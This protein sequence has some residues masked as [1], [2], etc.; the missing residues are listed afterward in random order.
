MEKARSYHLAANSLEVLNA[1]R[2]THRV[3]SFSKAIYRIMAALALLWLFAAPL[4]A[5]DWSYSVSNGEAII[6]R[7]TGAAN[8]VIVPATLNGLPVVR[9]DS[10]AISRDSIRSVALPA[11][12]RSLHSW[13]I[14]SAGLQSITVDPGNQTYSSSDGALLDKPGTTLLMYPRARAG[15]YTIP[16]G[17]RNITTSAFREARSLEA[18]SIPN[19]VTNISSLAFSQC[20]AL[21]NVTIPGSVQLIGQNAFNNCVRLA[22]VVVEPGVATIGVGAFSACRSLRTVQLGE[23]ITR[24]D[25]SAFSSCDNLEEIMLPNSLSTLLPSAF[26]QCRALKR[27]LVAATHPN[28][29]SVDGVLFNLAQTQLLIYPGG[30]AAEY[31]IPS[32]V[33]AIGDFAFSYAAGLAR[34]VG[35]PGLATIGAQ[36]F[37]SCTNLTSVTLQ[38]SV[39][40]IG[41]GAFG[42]CGEL[43]SFEIPPSVR[44][45]GSGAFS[46]SG[47][48]SISI[49]GSITNVA[50]Q[51][52]Q[53]CSNLQSVNFE[54][55]VK[56]I[57][58]SAFRSCSNLTE[59][60]LAPSVS[61]I[62][63]EAFREC[64]SLAGIRLPASVTNI[65][66]YAFTSTAL[67]NLFIPPTIQ[68]IGNYAFTY[69]Y[70]LTNITIPSGPLGYQALS[71]CPAL[72]SV[73][74]SG[75][76]PIFDASMFERSGPA[77]LHYLPGT[78]G[79]ER[80]AGWRLALWNPQAFTSAPAF[81]V[82][83]GRFGFVI[84]GTAG[85]PVVIEACSNLSEN[86]WTPI[87]VG[88]LENGFWYFVDE[89]SDQ[90][91]ARAYRWRAP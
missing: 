8:D 51:A 10:F 41:S 73:F 6:T 30:G 78:T 1:F 89:E 86:A 48:R 16:D 71:D 50:G 4:F 37:L 13:A 34:V 58:G 44:Q 62:E 19:T 80:Y 61:S 53:A 81:G 23:G 3:Q 69:C 57:S 29:A 28:F 74:F 45:L 68:R 42:S 75:N 43:T 20:E 52:F 36:A 7:Y 79:W 91:P 55:G 31:S 47:L 63:F 70:S 17:V 26:A 64:V 2:Q 40:S 25:G 38:N 82:R 90:Q 12:I 24:I 87:A 21:A 32:S 72:R 49:P 67:T 59:V 66:P 60:V 15:S 39:A 65:G 18:V 35:S 33:T 56:T 5:A 27:I 84:T 83:D 88:A 22:S 11:S 14:Y 46:F 85:I 76:A 54:F 9:L 77:Q